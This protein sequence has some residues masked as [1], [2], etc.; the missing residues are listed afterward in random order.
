MPF[1]QCFISIA[2]DISTGPLACKMECVLSSSWTLSGLHA[3]ASQEGEYFRTNI[4]A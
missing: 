2:I 3:R 1:L 4:Q